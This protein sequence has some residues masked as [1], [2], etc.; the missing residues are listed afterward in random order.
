[1]YV[2]I[3][4]NSLDCWLFIFINYYNIMFLKIIIFLLLLIFPANSYAKGSLYDFVVGGTIKTLAKIYVKTS[5]LT[6]LKSKYIKKITNMKD[7]KF[8][9][10]YMQFYDVYKELPPDLKQKYVFTDQV[11]KAEVIQKIDTVNKRDLIGIINKIP[12]DFILRKTKYYLHKSHEQSPHRP[13]VNEMFLWRSII[14][15]V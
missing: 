10:Y 12:S 13:V 1:M 9:K 5:N 15:K 7:D 6:K 14:Q 3:Y 4:K 8:N 2:K 11:T